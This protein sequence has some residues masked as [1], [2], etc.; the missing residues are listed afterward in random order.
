MFVLVVGTTVALEQRPML[1]IYLLSFWHYFIYWLAFAFGAVPFDIFK[2]DAVAMKT[3]S[4]AV[5][6][7]AYLSAPFDLV[8]LAVVAV[9]VLLNARAAAVLG[10]DRTYYGHEVAGLPPL[11]IAAFPYSSIA[12]PMIVGNV[13][14]FGGTLANADFARQWWPLAC[15][16]VVLNIGLLAM[17]LAGKSRERAVRRAGY[18]ILCGAAVV[19]AVVLGGTAETTAWLQ[20]AAAAGCAA[21]LYRRYTGR[22]T[23]SATPG[24]TA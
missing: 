8:S 5:L 10:F 4:V 24:R 3:V 14:A 13:L 6:A 22:T 18:A 15:T 16:H 7:A 20:L 17:E 2:R 19:A 1:A 23:A 21:I 12:H 9:G 11:R